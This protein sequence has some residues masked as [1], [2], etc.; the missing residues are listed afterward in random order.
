MT[1]KAVGD[2]H[3]SILGQDRPVLESQ[4][5]HLLPVNLS[6]EILIKTDQLSMRY[7]RW[8]KELGIEFG[9]AA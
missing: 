8:L 6:E 7:R 1:D 9:V 5:P 2:Y 3:K 4:R